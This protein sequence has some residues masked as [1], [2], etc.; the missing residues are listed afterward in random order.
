[1][2]TLYMAWQHQPS[3]R[4]FPVGRLIRDESDAGRF[5][6]AYVQGAR[7][8][9]KVAGFRGIPG[10]RRLDLRYRASELFPTFRNRIMNASRIDRPVYLHQLGLDAAGCDELA[11]LSVSGGRSYTDSFEVFQA[12]ETDADG[13]FCTQLVLH[14]LR[15]TNPHAIEEVQKLRSGD[16]LRVAV[17]LNNPITTH[18]ILV[19][20]QCYYVLGWLPRYVAEG[21]YRDRNWTVLDAKAAVAQVNHD[22]PLSH[23][24]LVDFSGRLPPGVNP[25]QDLAQYQPIAERDENVTGQAKATR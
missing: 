19:Y 3:R 25:M 18:A 20:T 24:L 23:R 17:E 10:F 7:E 6:F 1:M 12:I 15:H 8:A 5:E 21:M 11:E 4:W 2:T 13:R 16:E 9:E 22:A 14:G